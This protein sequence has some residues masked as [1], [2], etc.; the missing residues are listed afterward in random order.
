MLRRSPNSSCLRL[1]PHPSAPSGHAE[2]PPLPSPKN[3]RPVFSQCSVVVPEAHSA[4]VLLLR[5]APVYRAS[6]RIVSLLRSAHRLFAC[7]AAPTDPPSFFCF[8]F[9]VVVLCVPCRQCSAQCSGHAGLLLTKVT[10]HAYGFLCLC[11][12]MVVM[13]SLGVFYVVSINSLVYRRFHSP[14]P[15]LKNASFLGL[16]MVSSSR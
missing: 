16:W 5:G 6:Q 13:F 7:S 1:A 8:F 9:C 10:N 2:S 12:Y 3:L 11:F 14:L 15:V 4:V